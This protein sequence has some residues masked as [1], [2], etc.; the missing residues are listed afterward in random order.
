MNV[1]FKYVEYLGNFDLLREPILSYMLQNVWAFFSKRH[2]N[3]SL[4][5]HAMM[6]TLVKVLQKSC[7]CLKLNN[8]T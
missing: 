2:F 4:L 8:L 1:T 6:I 7:A 5:K 3:V